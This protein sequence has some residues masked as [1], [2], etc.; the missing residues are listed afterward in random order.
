MHIALDNR[1]AVNQSTAIFLADKTCK[2]PWAL[3]SNGDLYQLIEKQ[4]HQ[5]GL[6]S[7]KLT[8]VKGHATLRD[9]QTGRV[10]AASAIAN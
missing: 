5:R 10:D 8:W 4:A 7:C 3:C 6:H 2:K 9:I 1:T